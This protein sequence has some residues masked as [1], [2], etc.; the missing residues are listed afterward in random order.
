[1]ITA[2]SNAQ[3]QRVNFGRE[4]I[5]FDDTEIVNERDAQIAKVTEGTDQLKDIADVFVNSDNKM[6]QKAG[7][8]IGKLAQFIGIVA[9]AF[10]FSKFSARA[11]IEGGKKA[12]D[13]PIVK[14]SLEK[15]GSMK[16]PAI[17]FV[18]STVEKVS[19]F[20][21]ENPK[22]Q[23]ALT[24][25]KDSRVGT[26][27]KSA[28]NSEKLAPIMTPIKNTLS[29]TVGMLKDGSK[30]QKGVENLFGAS[31]ATSAVVNEVANKNP[32]TKSEA[33]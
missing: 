6:A 13:T 32:E 20:V 8:G 33:A 30:I 31:A 10:I 16:E 26:F 17:K 4:G 29:S 15:A 23:E 11:L 7:K 18:T 28:L 21:S 12:L 14:S 25:F 24:K 22:M 27:V 5:D 19:K 9:G 2:V 1:M 3:A